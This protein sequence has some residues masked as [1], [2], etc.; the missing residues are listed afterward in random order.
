MK[1]FKH[2]FIEGIVKPYISQEDID[3]V[4]QYILGEMPSK[5]K[6]QDFVNLIEI[7]LAPISDHATVNLI[8]DCDGCQEAPVG[9]LGFEGEFHMLWAKLGFPSVKVNVFANPKTKIIK[10]DWLPKLLRELK[11]TLEH[12]FIHFTQADKRDY[13]EELAMYKHK[14]R[15]NEKISK[16]TDE[17]IRELMKK[18]MSRKMRRSKLPDATKENIRYYGHEDEISAFSNDLKHYLLYYTNNDVNKALKLLKQYYKNPLPIKTPI[19]HYL[20]H[21]GRNTPII[22]KL[23][24]L[25]YQR[26]IDEKETH[27]EVQT[28]YF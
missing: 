14:R 16:M 20:E 10:R 19:D 17:E 27:Q 25:T 4:I 28:G 18:K 11:T 13:K 8:T 6:I 1:S 22:K 12:E 15:N 23:F 24:K 9:A 5:L 21:F 26:L 7:A 2:F 3:D